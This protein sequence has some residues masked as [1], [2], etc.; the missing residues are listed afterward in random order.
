MALILSIDKLNSNDSGTCLMRLDKSKTYIS[1]YK[2]KH[3]GGLVQDCSN[4]NMLTID[5]LQS[6][7][8][9]S[10]W[11]CHHRALPSQNLPEQKFIFLLWKTTCLERPSKLVVT[12]Y[13]FHCT[14]PSNH[15]DLHI[16]TLSA[17]L[18]QQIDVQVTYQ[19][20]T[21][22]PIMFFLI[23]LMQLPLHPPTHIKGLY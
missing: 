13:R 10:T 11:F 19:I 6:C 14:S 4:S 8:E 15:P 16:W 17:V 2:T 5:L 21:S 18:W 12:L 9:P 3:I 7:T 20:Y 1:I 22:C 23:Y